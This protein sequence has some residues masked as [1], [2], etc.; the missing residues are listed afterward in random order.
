MAQWMAQ[1]MTHTMD[2]TPH[3]PRCM[4]VMDLELARTSRTAQ[5]SDASAKAA[6]KCACWAI[7]A[8]TGISMRFRRY[9]SPLWRFT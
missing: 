4:S 2:G 6:L 5:K 3:G 7:S 8:G 9:T 1:P